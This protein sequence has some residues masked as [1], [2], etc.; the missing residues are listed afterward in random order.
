MSTTQDYPAQI[1]TRSWLANILIILAGAGLIYWSFR[2]LQTRLTSV[3][4]RDAVIN[5]V[6][7][8]LKAPAAGEVSKLAV[9]TGEVAGKDNVL[10]TL[11]NERVSQLEV[12][13]ITSRLNEQKAELERAQ[14]QLSRQLALVKTLELDHQNQSNLQVREAKQSVAQVQSDLQ[15]AQARYQLAQVNYKRTAFL[16]NEGALPKAE[17]DTV[18]LEMQESKAEINRLNARLEA[19]RADEKAALVGLSLDR[20]SSNYDPKIRLQELL[21]DIADQQ[22]IIQTLQQTVKDA[23]AELAQAQADMQRQQTVEVKTPT[24]GVIWRLDTQKG[25]FV[26]EGDTLGNVVD[27]GRRWV[28]VYVEERALRSLQPGTPATIELYGSKSQVFQGKVSL[29]RSGLGR[30][31]AGEDVAIPLTPNLPRDSQVRVE[32]APDTDKGEPNLFCYVGYTARVS[33]QVN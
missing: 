30:L 12:Q 1:S 13:E 4:S 27:C 18:K 14:A 32:L 21:L 2:L 20:S 28:D 25:Q 23:Q 11:K 22:K 5:G 33:F 6:L 26:E 7:I 10:L 16:S 17:L 15:A 24:T 19:A 31:A 29:V 8:E 9:E 3:I